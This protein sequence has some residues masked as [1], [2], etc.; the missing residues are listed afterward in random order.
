MKNVPIKFRGKRVDNGRLAFGYYVPWTNLPTPPRVPNRN[1]LL[2]TNFTL[3]VGGACGLVNEL[4]VCI[5]VEAD[6]VAQLIGYDADGCEVYEGDALD[7][8]HFGKFNCASTAKLSATV[9][10]DYRDE[11]L[12][13]NFDFDFFANSR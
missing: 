13:R 1:E 10:V 3:E 12:N 4:G 9:E 5:A 7:C 8:Y 2:F 6:S 11:D